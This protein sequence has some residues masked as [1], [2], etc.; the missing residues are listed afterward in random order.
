MHSTRHWRFDDE[1]IVT[2]VLRTASVVDDGTRGTV[3]QEQFST[4]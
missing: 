4:R 1:C 2:R 3:L